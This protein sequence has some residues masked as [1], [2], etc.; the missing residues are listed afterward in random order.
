[1]T[2]VALPCDGHDGGDS[3]DGTFECYS[4][5]DN[6]VWEDGEA[7]QAE[8]FDNP[9]SDKSVTGYLCDDCVDGSSHLV[10]FGYDPCES[11]DR[12]ICNRNPRN[13]YQTWFRQGVC[14]ACYQ[15]EMLER[16]QPLSDFEGVSSGVKGDFYDDCDLIKAG[17]AVVAG[18]TNVKVTNAQARAYRQ[19]ALSFVQAGDAII[20][21]YVSLSILGDEG[22]VT[23][24][25][26]PN[27]DRLDMEPSLKRSKQG[28]QDDE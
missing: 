27:I 12:Y 5:G 17:Y 20:T 14:C 3:C 25:R 28:E 19:T 6:C 15:E 4:C 9:H 10:E 23:M 26:R 18:S 11:C 7:R 2:T 24:W 16:G 22:Y 13:G 8:F 21:Q 1:M